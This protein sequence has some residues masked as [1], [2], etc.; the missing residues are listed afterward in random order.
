MVSGLNHW[1][2]QSEIEHLENTGHIEFKN[3]KDENFEDF[4][5]I[6]ENETDLIKPSENTTY[7]GDGFVFDPRNVDAPKDV[8]WFKVSSGGTVIIELQQNGEYHIQWFE[9]KVYKY[10]GPILKGQPY[11]V[12]FVENKGDFFHPAVNNS[13]FYK[14]FIH[15]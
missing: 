10:V 4:R 7:K 5:I 13:P 11:K 1:V 12:G 6:P 15:F 3:L 2:H 9:N 14:Y 8:E